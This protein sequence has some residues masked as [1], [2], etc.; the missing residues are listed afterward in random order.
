LYTIRNKF[1][2]KTLY[3]IGSSCIKKFGREDLSSIAGIQKDMFGLLH[4]IDEGRFI[5]LTSD[6]FTRKLLNE[7][8]EEG[9]FDS[10]FNG[11]NGEEDYVF[12]LKMFNKR[13]KSS[14]TYNQD[15]K[16]KAIIINSIKPYL[17]SKLNSKIH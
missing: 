3:P 8:F 16:I 17:E 14:I 15:K 4:A 13:D 5:S 6:L 2:N 9:A 12:M 10:K 7:L 1:N 11:F